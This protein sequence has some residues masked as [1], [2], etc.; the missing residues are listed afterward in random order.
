MIYSAI[1]GTG[2]YL[3][4]RILTNHDLE[5]MVDTSDSWIRERTG[6]E[7][8]HLAGE[9]DSCTS[10][11]V[12]A[13]KDSLNA[14]SVKPD[15]VDLVIVATATPDRAFPS[16]ACHVQSALGIKKGAAFD[17]SAAC[18]GFIYALTLADN[19]IK[20]GSAKTALV[21]GSEMISRYIDWTDRTTCILFSDGAG[22]CILQASDTPGII[23]TDLGSD[24]DYSE[25]LYAN[26]PSA[27][28]SDKCF[29][30]MKGNEVFKKAV[31]TLGSLIDNLVK[32][33]G[34]ATESIDWLIPHQANKRIIQATAKKLGLP[35]DKVIMTVAKHGNTSAASIPLALDW[36]IKQGKIKPGQRLFLE[37]FGAGF[38]WGSA[39]IDYH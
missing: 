8:R 37:A 6:I 30:Q 24:G 3:P 11:A 35:M 10:M 9:K 2:S 34:I 12:A 27:Y 36:G 31:N 26:H 7:C 32:K 4:K 5:Q 14:S 16:V 15:D 21:I 22:A 25:L 29:L 28:P 20:A 39:L 33:H 1:K 18:S 19:A 13:A 23:T 38:T 17:V